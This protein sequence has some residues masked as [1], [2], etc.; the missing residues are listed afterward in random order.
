VDAATKSGLLDLLEQATRQGWTVRAACQVLELGELR[1][2]RWLGRRVAGELED[3]APGGSPMH[4]LLDWEI[5]EILRLFDEWGEVDGSHRKLAHRGSYLERVWVSPASVRRVLEREGLRLRPPP[6]PGRSIRKP[7]PDWVTYTPN[8]IWIY[9]TTHFTRAGVAATVIEDLVSR[10]WLAEIVSAEETSTQVQ[11][12]FTDALEAEGLLARVAARQDGLVD[13]SVDD[14]SRPVLLALSD[15]APADDQ[16]LHPGIHGPVR[17]PPALRPARHPDRPGLDRVTVRP[18]QGRMAPPERDL[19]PGDLARRAR[20]R[21][22][23]LQRGATARRNRLRHPQRRAPGP[24]SGDPQGP[25][26]RT[27]AGTPPA[28]CLASRAPSV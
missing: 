24:R 16:R 3:Q 1:V 26:G 25:P 11:V 21:A 27:G 15:N 20:G 6:R 18:R 14:L 19:R 2:Y 13:P 12:V 9:D 28:A 23:A 5:A 17:H 7:F 8:S 10:K 4:G 22:G